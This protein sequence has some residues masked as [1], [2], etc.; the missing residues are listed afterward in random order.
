MKT[1]IAH[2]LDMYRDLNVNICSSNASRGHLE[3]CPKDFL[4]ILGN[5]TFHN[6]FI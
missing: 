6:D 2:R 1:G 5:V 4:Y 3:F